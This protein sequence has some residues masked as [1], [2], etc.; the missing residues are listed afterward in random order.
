MDRPWGFQVSEAPK[1]QDSRHMKVVRLLAL[2]IDRLYPLENIPGVHLLLEAE[3]T[4]V[5]PEGL[6][7]WNL[8]M[9]PSH[10]KSTSL[11]GSHT[12]T[13][14]LNVSLCLITC[15]EGV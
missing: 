13:S 10:R 4:A 11:S 12:L 14:D 7:Q 15:N 2:R 9:T 8:P 6:C 1:F 3:S 5:R